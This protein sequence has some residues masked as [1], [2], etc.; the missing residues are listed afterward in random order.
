MCCSIAQ[1]NEPVLPFECLEVII[2]MV[3]IIV[4]IDYC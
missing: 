4:I 3:V 1:Y 2:L